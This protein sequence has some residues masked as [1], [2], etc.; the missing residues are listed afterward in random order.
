[1]IRVKL[2][3][4]RIIGITF[5]YTKYHGIRFTHCELY[6]VEVNGEEKP[7][8]TLMGEAKIKCSKDDQ[9]RKEVGRK[10]ALTAAMLDARYDSAA[11]PGG[12][13]IKDYDIEVLGK[14]D[15]EAIWDGY[16]LRPRPKSVPKDEVTVH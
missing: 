4:G 15:R 14:Q 16:L 10:H 5:K 8:L 6:L 3:D 11:I 1:M 9:F 7:K 2:S 12:S 13:L